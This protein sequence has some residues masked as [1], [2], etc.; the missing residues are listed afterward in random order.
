[1]QRR[2]GPLR[3]PLVPLSGP[4]DTHRRTSRRPRVPGWRRC[5]CAPRMPSLA[6]LMIFAS[7]LCG[8]NAALAQ[9]AVDAGLLADINRIRAIDNHMHGDAVD[10]RGRRA[11]KTTRR[12]ESRVIRRWWACSPRIPNGGRPGS[13]CMA[14][15]MPTPTRHT[16]APAGDQ[17]R[18]DGQGGANWPSIVLDTAGVDIA[19]L[20]TV[21]PGTGQTNGRF[22]W[23]PYADPLL[24][25]FAGIQL[26]GIFG[27]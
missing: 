4:A 20:N 12:S 25:P 27:R 7:M 19:L 24:R 22:R 13:R 5:S 3:D 14:T 8:A 2:P 10:P 16:C 6:R 9:D 15:A 18:D 1:M 21:R 11:G 26:A 23:V 17:A